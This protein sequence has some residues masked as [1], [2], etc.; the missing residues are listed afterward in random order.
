MPDL[1][2]LIT[3]VL[4]GTGLSS[5]RHR[6][7]WALPRLRPPHRPVLRHA[8]ELYLTS[9]YSEETWT[10]GLRAMVRPCV[11]EVVAEIGRLSR[12]RVS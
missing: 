1:A 12:H 4:A 10:E 9:R 6:L 11:D 5:A 3:M 7:S 2:L 8:R